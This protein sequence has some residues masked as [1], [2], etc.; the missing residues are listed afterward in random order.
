MAGSALPSSPSSGVSVKQVKISPFNVANLHDSVSIVAPEK[1][2]VL[3]AEKEV[4]GSTENRAPAS[5]Q[6]NRTLDSLLSVSETG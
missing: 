2:Y 4:A 5:S 6:L 3:L 1:S